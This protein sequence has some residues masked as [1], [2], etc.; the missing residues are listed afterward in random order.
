MQ[1]SNFK[2]FP[3]IILCAFLFLPS[4]L[5]A[6]E[7]SP[8]ITAIMEAMDA[9]REDAQAGGDKDGYKSFVQNEFQNIFTNIKDLNDQ[10]IAEITFAEINNK[11]EAELN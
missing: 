1:I 8:E 7:E 10:E 2:L 3:L 11:I 9:G 4:I 5:L 6:Q